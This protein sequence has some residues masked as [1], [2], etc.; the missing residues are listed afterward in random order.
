MGI[1]KTCNT[2]QAQTIQPLTMIKHNFFPQILAYCTL[3][4]KRD[5]YYMF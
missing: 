4:S 3:Q 5:P 1:G 2:I